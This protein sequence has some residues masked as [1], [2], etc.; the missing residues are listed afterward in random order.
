MLDLR[1]KKILVTG[2]AGFLG[3]YIIEELVQ[4][5]V[6]RENIFIPRK[7]EYDL[8]EW[9]ACE[10]VMRDQE[11]VFHLAAL[12]GG[13]G[14]NRDHPGKMFY[15]NMVM[16][17]Q[18]M[19]AA[20]LA[21]VK[22][23]VNIGTI[24]SYPKFTPVPFSEDFLWNGYPEETNA[25]Y[26]LAKRALLVQAEAYSKQYGFPS[27]YLLQANL[28]GPRDSFNLETSHVIPALIKKFVDAK[29]MALDF[30]DLWGTGKPTRAFLYAGDAARG[31]LLAAERYDKTE[32]VNLG[33]G[34]EISIRRL[35]EI[36]G[37]LTGF[38][39]EIRWDTSKPDGQPRRTLD[40]NRAEKEFGFRAKTD[41][42]EGLRE[43]IEWYYSQRGNRT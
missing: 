31:I 41:F 29:D 4:R 35:A 7:E 5:K 42:R 12:V 14:L 26:G 17:A 30:V 16:G 15:D 2:G 38:N 24:C 20:R 28:Y 27:I 36:I 34:V 11:I 22:K 33:T 40:T 23:F 18:L 6:S 13:I 3:S 9:E 10:K 1:D 8:R 32:A 19:E 43:T 37:E 39:G 21:G 25:P